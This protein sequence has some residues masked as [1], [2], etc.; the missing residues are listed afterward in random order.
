ML[1]K[2][3]FRCKRC[4]ECC[5][6]CIIVLNKS[7]IKRIKKV[8]YREE[9]FLEIDAGGKPIL[10]HINGKCVFLEKENNKY[11]CKIYAI[12]PTVCKKYP[13]FGKKVNSCKPQITF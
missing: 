5:K 1:N 9:E 2:K 10:R 11:S 7:D 13:F 8:G 6:K 4:G 3:T 12:R